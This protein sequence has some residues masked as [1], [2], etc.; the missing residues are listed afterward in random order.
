VARGDPHVPRGVHRRQ[1]TRRR[2]LRRGLA[3]RQA[4]P[5]PPR[6]VDRSPRRTRPRGAGAGRRRRLGG[7]HRRRG[8]AAQACGDGGPR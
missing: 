3:A 1:C 6:R 5:L 2:R 4:R 8:A 7:A